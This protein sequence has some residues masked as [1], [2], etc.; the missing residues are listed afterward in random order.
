[1]ATWTHK[2]ERQRVAIERKHAWRGAAKSPWKR[3]EELTAN[4]LRAT[5]L[6]RVSTAKS[7]TALVKIIWPWSQ[8]LDR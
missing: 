2:I 7:T 4:V 1:M 8:Q 5:T 6:Q 3:E